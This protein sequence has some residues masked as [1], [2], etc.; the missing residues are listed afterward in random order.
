MINRKQQIEIAA[1]SAI[2]KRAAFEPITNGTSS[3]TK[4]K[5]LPI[6]NI[7]LH[8]G[9]NINMST[10][11]VNQIMSLFKEREVEL[12]KLVDPRNAVYQDC[13]RDI[14]HTR[15][16]LVEWMN[17]LTKKMGCPNETIYLAVQTFDRFLHTYHFTNTE[18]MQVATL[19]SFYIA[20]KLEDTYAPSLRTLISYVGQAISKEQVRA[21][22]LTILAELDW[23]FFYATPIVFL[24]VF[25]QVD[26]LNDRQRYFAF[27]LAELALYNQSMNLYTSSQVAAASISLAK[28]CFRAQIRWTPE[29]AN[30][31]GLEKDDFNECYQQ[32][33]HILTRATRDKYEGIFAKYDDPRYH[34]VTSLIVKMLSL[35]PR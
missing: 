16:L 24:R 25:S 19:A 9:Y 3:Y 26:Q 1:G 10:P 15:T 21:M 11:Y 17:K 28:K 29:L 13:V 4:A 20:C 32:L 12:Q 27:F 35:S 5:P 14:V 31:S 33:V 30:A 23:S 22:E 7:D 2:E 8:V 34:N 6:D 18:Q